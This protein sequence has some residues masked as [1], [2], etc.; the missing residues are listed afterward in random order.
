MSAARAFRFLHASDLHLDS[1]FRG[2]VDVAPALAPALRDATFR[3]FDGLVRAAIA[4]KVDFVLL[5]GDLYDAR[6]RSLRAQLALRDGLVK[7]DQAGIGAYVVHG[8][9]DPLGG[10]YA[11][12]SLPGSAHV[13]GERVSTVEVKRDG[14]TIATVS[15]VSYPRAEML[16]NLAKT[17]PRPEG[18]PFAIGLLHANLGSDTGHA[19]YAPCTLSDLG[20]SG[21]RYWA[22]GHVHAQ[23][24]QR[25][26][27]GTVVAYPGNPQGRSI[28]ET[29]PRGC[30]LVEVS[31]AGDVV[32]RPLIL[33]AVRWHRPSVSIDGVATADAL[34]EKITDEIRT[35]IQVTD[36]EGHSPGGH[37]FRIDLVGRGPLHAELARSNELFDLE[38]VLR[39]QW[40]DR[41]TPGWFVLVERLVDDTGREVDRPALL[42]ERTLLGDALRLAREAKQP[43]TAREELK[44]ALETMLKKTKD[45]L[46]A[47][48]EADF[49][50][51]LE[52]AAELAIDALDA[53]EKG[54]A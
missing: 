37:V 9:H 27:N 11:Q 52:R 39:G 5:A 23:S 13:F 31:A 19:S 28:R 20:A 8:N 24:V 43:G 47:P 34:L 41:G 33:D 48:T 46:E 17:F 1:P 53:P 42:A 7:L 2:Q 6:D 45:V 40:L 54:A 49:D 35:R 30:L 38:R 25:T 50:R 51:I 10:R 29:G 18:S 16:D 22:L 36:S 4:E 32:T 26:D 12:I 44:A 15:G 3:A 14:E 21:H